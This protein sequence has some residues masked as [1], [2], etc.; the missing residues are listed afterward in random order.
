MASSL[1]FIGDSCDRRE[2]RYDGGRTDAPA[3]TPGARRGPKKRDLRHIVRVILIG[4]AHLSRTSVRVS[5]VRIGR[6][7]YTGSYVALP[8]GAPAP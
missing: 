8:T 2:Q 3:P 5:K 6:M 7:V 4:L 1:R